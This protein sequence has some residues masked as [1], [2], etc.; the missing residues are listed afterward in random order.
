[1]RGLHR[2]AIQQQRWTGK[3]SP[4]VEVGVSYVVQSEEAQRAV[5]A[6]GGQR[7]A[8]GAE[9]QAADTT[10][11]P[12]AGPR[13]PSPSV[14][15]PVKGSP[16]VPATSWKWKARRAQS[17]HTGTSAQ[18]PPLK[19]RPLVLP[20]CLARPSML[21]PQLKFT[22]AACC[23]SAAQGYESC[24]SGDQTVPTLRKEGTC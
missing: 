1:M 23:W 7:G 15:H 9:R 20:W 10:L 4:E 21:R 22:R 12:L 24:M 3:P 13:T 2:P 16:L 19:A 14:V 18:P 5:L 11:M 6:D 8:V 17:S